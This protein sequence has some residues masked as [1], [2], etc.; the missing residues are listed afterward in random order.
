MEMRQAVV[1]VIE[2]QPPLPPRPSR[3]GRTRPIQFYRKILSRRI[4]RGLLA[5]TQSVSFCPLL[6][7]S[8][9]VGRQR[10]IHLFLRLPLLF[11]VFH[12]YSSSSTRLRSN[13]S[14]LCDFTAS[15]AVHMH[16]KT[17]SIG[18]DALNT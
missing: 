18:F 11:F 3:H 14:S 16:M 8:G 6:N 13:R 15:F 7:G 9:S 4:W 12:F 1:I 2:S 5:T 17:L 10:F